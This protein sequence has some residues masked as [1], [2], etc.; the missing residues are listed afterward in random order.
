MV[1]YAA[2]CIGVMFFIFATLGSY[3]GHYS[4]MS[5]AWYSKESMDQ[6]QYLAYLLTYVVSFPLGTIL[7]L[8]DSNY[9]ADKWFAVCVPNFIIY[10]Y[11]AEKIILMINR[12]RAGP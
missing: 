8:Y 7:S 3:E 11:L 12:V 9:L 1:F 10:F 2:C 6:Y 4:K 5:G